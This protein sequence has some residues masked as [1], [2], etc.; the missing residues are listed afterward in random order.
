MEDSSQKLA[1]TKLPFDEALLNARSEVN[2][3]LTSMINSLSDLQQLEY[4]RRLSVGLSLIEP[5]RD[6]RNEERLA[7]KRG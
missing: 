3:I 1:Y 5:Y 4:D 2:E 6:A 7:K